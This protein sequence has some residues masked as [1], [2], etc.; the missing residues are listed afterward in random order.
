MPCDP[1]FLAK[2]RMFDHLNED[3]RNCVGR[4]SQARSC[5]RAIAEDH[6]RLHANKLHRMRADEIGIPGR[7]AILKR[8]IFAGAP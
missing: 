6:V 4:L 3:D 8:D 5:R 2:I 7:P 1:N